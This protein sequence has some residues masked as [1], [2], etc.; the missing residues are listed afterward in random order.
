METVLLGHDFTRLVA[1]ELVPAVSRFQ[2]LKAND[3]RLFTLQRPVCWHHFMAKVQRLL[4]FSQQTKSVW[5]LSRA[6]IYYIYLAH[7]SIVSRD[8]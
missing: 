7:V 1:R 2:Q 3:Y 8:H 6:T 5:L 4:V